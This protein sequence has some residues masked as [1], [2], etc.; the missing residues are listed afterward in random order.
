MD[1]RSHNTI[2]GRIIV[3]L[4]G[5]VDSAV[6][7]LLLKRK[8]YDVHGL[9]MKNWEEDDEDGYCA[10]EEDLSAA[11]AVANKLDI[12]LDTVNFSSEYWDRV[13]EYF[14]SEL[15]EGRTPNPDILC[16]REIKFQ[17][18]LDYSLSK[19][20]EKI[21]TGHYACSKRY[22][23]NIELRRAS[24]LDKDQTYFLHQVAGTALKKAL[25]PLCR[26]QKSDVRQMA[27]DA[28]L[29]NYDR[30]DSTGICFIGERRFNDFIARYFPNKPGDILTTDH[31]KIGEHRG[32]MFHT[33][34]QRKG[35]GIGGRQDSAEEPWFVT[36]KRMEDNT[37]IVA[38]GHDNP[39]LYANGLEAH[40]LHW[41][42]RTPG[43]STFHCTARTRHRQK[44]VP[45]HV[46]LDDASGCIVTFEQPMRA[47]APGQS[48]VFYDDQVCLGGGVIQRAF[49][50]PGAVR[51]KTG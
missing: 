24:D 6:A 15:S 51:I 31:K 8:G 27:L 12:P 35:L 42:T 41:I 37:L 34:G 17:A 49:Q 47:I 38:Q 29:A 25:F 40:S 22:P 45:C 23:D 9:F 26:Y 36:E 3:G 18:F 11:K 13:F 14:L 16:N 2:E 7:A 46:Q 30:K 4:S 44:D 50:L 28:G 33:I 21:A 1:E 48:V 5:G 10:A 32:L 20:A 39:A 43:E 19:G